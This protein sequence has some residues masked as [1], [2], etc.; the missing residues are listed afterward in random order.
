[1]NEIEIYERIEQYL[2][3][4]LSQEE[5]AEMEVVM[6]VDPAYTK[7]L[8]QQKEIFNFI[9]ESSLADIREHMLSIHKRKTRLIQVRNKILWAGAI[10]IALAIIGL[11]L[12]LLLSDKKDRGGI[13]PPADISESIINKESQGIV[14]VAINHD[15]IQTTEPKA[16]KIETSR[17]TT[18]EENVTIEKKTIETIPDIVSSDDKIP[19]ADTIKEAVKTAPEKD[20]S[21]FIKAEDT[22][23]G[24]ETPLPEAL[25]CSQVSILAEVK[26]APSCEHEPTGRLLIETSSVSGGTPPYE[27]SVDNQASYHKTLVRG[28]LPPDK[29]SVWIRDKNKCATWMGLF[30]VNTY[31][32][33]Y[34][35]VFAPDEGEMW[36][37][38]N[39]GQ[40]CKLW[41]YN[42]G[43][44]L[45][46][47][48]SYN[49][50]GTFY[51]DGR[52][53]T[54]EIVPMGAY[55]FILTIEN[56][57]PVKGTVTVIR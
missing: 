14:P 6:A 29:Y 48:N 34:E 25:D 3:G 11:T 21:L 57:A 43:G 20:T 45:V 17:T 8:A 7:A 52:K 31:K 18:K 28:S 55:S 23:S 50:P 44:A 10:V 40:T 27:L 9:E 2:S 13:V 24:D 37:I 22:E 30:T 19:Q 12:Y 33:I 35:D 26:V 4:K 54:G 42:R 41:I 53:A 39:R 51:W 46:F 56:E 47:E 32:C 49:F 16:P 15:T 1:M 5:H 36:E 38:P